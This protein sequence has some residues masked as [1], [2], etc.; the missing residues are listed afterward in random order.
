MIWTMPVMV[1]ALVLA[2]IFFHCACS[3]HGRVG[4]HEPDL[5]LKTG[6]VLIDNGHYSST[7]SGLVLGAMVLYVAAYATGL[8]NIPWQQGELFRLEVR[9]IGTSI[10]TAVN[11]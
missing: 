7:W 10:C 9:G 8:G 1:L 6:G 2:A 3:P 11:W 4:T 5:T